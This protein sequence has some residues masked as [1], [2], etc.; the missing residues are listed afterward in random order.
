M[1]NTS[2]AMTSSSRRDLLHAVEE[3]GAE[4]EVRAGASISS[5]MPSVFS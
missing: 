2:S 5:T 1:P 3:A 4:E